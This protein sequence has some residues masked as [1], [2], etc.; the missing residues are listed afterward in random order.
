MTWHI[1]IRLVTFTALVT[2]AGCGRAV[3]TA[4][5]AGSPVPSRTCHA[6]ATATEAD[7]G[8]TYCLARLAHLEIFL[9]GSAQD[10]WSPIKPDGDAL[11]R[12]PSGKGM[13]ALGVT[14]GFFIAEHA[15]TVHLTSTRRP[16]DRPAPVKDC[17]PFR[18]FE[19]TVIVH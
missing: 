12:S 11:R 16:C 15:G 13:L 14:G 8:Q 6:V 18:D 7:S 9:H 3:H 1:A 10:R 5:P 17:G 4:P 2:S 19:I